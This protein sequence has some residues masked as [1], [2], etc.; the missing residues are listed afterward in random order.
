MED[1]AYILDYLA[2]GRIGDRRQFRKE[3]LALAI[4]ETEYKLFELTLKPNVVLQIGDRVYIGKDIEKRKK[5]AHVK[6]RIGYEAL[7]GTA[8]SELSYILLEIVR[9]NE[10]KF[11]EFYNKSQAISPRFHILELLPGLGKKTMFAILGERKKGEFKSFED[12]RARV[13]ALHNPD[14][15]IAKRIEYELKDKRQKY[16]IFVTH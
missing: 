9:A 3:P 16:H 10:E 15:L 11:I 6:S 12:L 7:T 2:Q 14:K 8:Q 1:Y 4:G 13:P 5:I